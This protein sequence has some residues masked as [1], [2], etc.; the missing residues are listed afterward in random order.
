[1]TAEPML[2]VRYRVADRRVET[3]DSVTV[4]LEP[5]DRPLASFRPGQFAMLYAYGV[6]E[7]PISISGIGDHST[8]VH[9]IRSVGAVSRA[10][11][12]ARP[13]SVIGVRG[14]FGTAWAPE[15]AAGNDLVMVAGGIGLAPLRPLVRGVLARRP[16]Y[17]RIVLVAGARTPDEFLFRAELDRWAARTDLEVELTVDRPAVGWDG[18]V[19]FVT[20]PLSRLHVD[21][22]RTVAFLCGPEPMMRFGARV[23]LRRGMGADRIRVSLE[24]SMKCGVALCG[25]CQ[26]GPLLICRDGPVVDYATAEPLLAVPQL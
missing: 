7:V 4:R 2:P 16:A 25:H 13:G 21:P 3:R 6:G 10:L 17:R 14:P 11:Y 20:E 18:A 22:S 5:V 19:G 24:R 8:L 26:L 12:D 15:D 9:T 23:L 1:M